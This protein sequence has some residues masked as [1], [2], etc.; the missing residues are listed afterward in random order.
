LA[1]IP[2][3]DGRGLP[4]PGPGNGG[5]RDSSAN[6]RPD[7]RPLTRGR[8]PAAQLRLEMLSNGE[9]HVFAPGARRNLHADR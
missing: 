6:L 5:T 4:P 9:G 2:D 3:W 1:D 8:L 7:L